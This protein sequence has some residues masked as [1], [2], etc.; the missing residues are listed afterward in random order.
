MYIIVG[1][2]DSLFG[3]G[4]KTKLDLLRVGGDNQYLTVDARVR[5]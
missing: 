2:E 3:N 5:T 1:Q 4:F